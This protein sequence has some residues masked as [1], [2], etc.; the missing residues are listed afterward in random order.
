MCGFLSFLFVFWRVG[1]W[2]GCVSC[3]VLSI[4]KVCWMCRCVYLRVFLLG[5]DL[6][7][8]V[9]RRFINW[10]SAL[11]NQH[12]EGVERLDKDKGHSTRRFINAG[13]FDVVR[14]PVC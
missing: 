11:Q 4:G 3:C 8:E 7:R 14:R 13:D 1:A 5:I 2:L 10:I 12:G 9:A 6:R